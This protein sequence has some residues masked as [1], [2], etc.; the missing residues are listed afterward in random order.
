M[1]YK[2]N[3][4]LELVN[5]IKQA[6]DQHEFYLDY[7]PIFD[8]R[9]NEIV[10]LEALVRWNHPQ[11]G[12]IYPGLF[13]PIAE[14]S[15]FMQALDHIILNQA[16]LD[17]QSVIKADH[18]PKLS[19]NISPIML[20]KHDFSMRLS[21]LIEQYHINSHQIIIEISENTFMNNIEQSIIQI[22]QLKALGVLV[23]LD[24][25]G[26][27]FSSLSIL[28]QVDF[29]LIKIDRQFVVNLSSETNQEIIKMVRKITRLKDKHLIVEGVETIEQVNI[30]SSLDCHLMQGYFYARPGQLNL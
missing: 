18:K 19:I 5:E 21:Q 15:G 12:T 1:F 9:T 29:D 28:N 30:L 16:F 17:Y 2:V 27:E 10:I 22:N 24:D 11:K 4:K 3:Q 26:R 14:E 23:A 7:Q 6:I 8:Q 20:L 25:F 13:I